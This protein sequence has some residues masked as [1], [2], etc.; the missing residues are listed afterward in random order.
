MVLYRHVKNIILI[1]LLMNTF[2]ISSTEVVHAMQPPMDDINIYVKNYGEKG[3]YLDVLIEENEEYYS[4]FSDGIS[5]DLKNSNLYKYR[6]GNW[7]AFFIRGGN[8]NSFLKNSF[9]GEETAEKDVKLHCFCDNF[10]RGEAMKVIV[11]M[12][13]NN[14]I[15]SN[16]VVFDHKKAYI[17]D[18]KTKRL[19]VINPYYL[20]FIEKS[21]PFTAVLFSVIFGLAVK[22]FVSYTFCINRKGCVASISAINQI[23]QYFI[24]YLLVSD[25]LFDRVSISF[26]SLTLILAAGEYLVYRRFLKDSISLLKMF[27][28]VIISNI[29]VIPFG[30]IF[31]QG[32]PLSN[33]N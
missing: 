31:L 16:P 17:F 28:F 20:M 3:Y 8:G 11:Q 12:P 24:M 4:F 9:M 18:T 14:L 30:W 2:L 29:L 25:R 5:K 32:F 6:D 15:V 26:V 1:I 7:M 21:F 13:D 27:S 23:I 10:I 19:E 22:L 33:H